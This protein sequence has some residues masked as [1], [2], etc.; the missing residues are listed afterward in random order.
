MYPLVAVCVLCSFCETNL[1]QANAPECDTP[2]PDATVHQLS[3]TI[4][5]SLTAF[6]PLHPACQHLKI[7]IIVTACHRTFLSFS[8]GI[9][10]LTK[11]SNIYT[12]KNCS[13]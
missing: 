3:Y 7:N 10:T 11:T 1:R 12:F 6:E 4:F 5:C 8:F 2:T 13:D 9:N